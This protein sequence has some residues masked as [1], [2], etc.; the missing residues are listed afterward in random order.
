MYKDLYLCIYIHIYINTYFNVYVHI[1][2]I[3]W[4]QLKP[5]Y[6]LK[7]MEPSRFSPIY[8][9][10]HIQIY[11]HIY[12]NMYIYTD[13]LIYIH[14]YTGDK[15]VAIKTFAQFEGI[16]N[17]NGSLPDIYTHTYKYVYIQICTY[18][19]TF[20]YA[21]ILIQE[22]YHQ[23]LG[24]SHSSREYGTCTALS[25]IYTTCGIRIPGE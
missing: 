18:I 4:V 19:Q 15:S 5:L 24:L 12:T 20:K 2:V 25:R 8:I 21:Y 16:W 22:M 7:E 1:Q 9:Y 3:Y 6:S 10:I 13:F 11:I 14:T 17:V 23:Q